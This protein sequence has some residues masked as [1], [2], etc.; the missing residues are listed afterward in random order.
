MSDTGTA[1]DPAGPA[2]R[3]VSADDQVTAP[4]PVVGPAPRPR[5]RLHRAGIH[6]VW[7]YDDQVFSFADGRLLL[8]G[9]N[10]AGKSKALEVLLP[11]LLDGDARRLDTTGTGRTSLR[12]LMQDGRSAAVLDDEDTEETSET[13]ESGGTAAAGS[14][15]GAGA[16]EG[17]GGPEG[18][19]GPEPA[20]DTGA[21]GTE[22]EGADTGADAAPDAAPVGDPAPP[23][24]AADTAP[25]GD[26]TEDTTS[27]EDTAPPA[28]R[29]GY[30]WIEFTREADTAAPGSRKAP[31][32]GADTRTPGRL[33]LGAAVTAVPGEE[34]RTLFFVTGRSVGDDLELVRGG[35]PVP[36]ERLRAEL[37][38]DSCYDSAPAYRGRVMRDLFGLDDPVRYRNLVHL[39]YRLRRPTIGERLEAGELVSVLAE[40]LP[41]MDEAVLDQVARNV[42]DLEEARSR[43]TALTAAAENVRAFLGDYRGYLHGVLG[44]RTSRVRG[45]LDGFGRRDAEAARLEEELDRLV[46]EEAAAQEERDRS[47]RTRDTAASDAA[48]LTAAGRAEP[49]PA[50]G[51]LQARDAAVAAYIRAAESA[52]TA[53]G[54]A[55]T[56]EER[57]IAA[58]GTGTAAVERTL[59][60]LEELHAEAADGARAAGMDPALLGRVPRPV[61]TV[62]TPRESTTHVDFEGLERAVERDPV[63]GIDL[64]ALR[65]GLADLHDRLSRAEAEAAERAA[66][67]ASLT[68]AA[69]RLDAAERRADALEG[70]AEAADAA[71]ERAR[72][73]EEAAVRALR[74]A[75]ADYA[76]RV[77]D[78]ARGVAEGFPEAAE[79]A[80]ALEELVHL[81]PG[82]GEAVDAGLC[83][84]VGQAAHALVDDLLKELRVRRD[85][86][87]G[88]ERELVT[89][90]DELSERKRGAAGDGPD[91]TPLYLLVDFAD[92]LSD[93]ERV[94]LEAALA[95]SGLLDARLA[96]DGTAQGSGDGALDGA[97]LAPGRP[98]DGASLLDVLRVADGAADEHGVPRDRVE[99]LLSSVAL[100][101]VEAG[102][103][104]DTAPRHRRRRDGE[105]PPSACAVAVDGRWRLGVASGAAGQIP[106]APERIGAGARA[107]ARDRR[108]ANVDRRIDIA[109]ALLAEAGERRAEAERAQERLVAAARALPG[110]EGP[111]R[112]RAALDEARAWL[113]TAVDEHDRAQEAADAAR[114]TALG[115]RTAVQEEAA[116]SGL[117]EG[118]EEAAATGTAVEGLR[119]RTGAA[120]R[121]LR[122]LAALLEEHRAAVED[123]R[124]ARADRVVAEDARTAAIGD[125]ITVRR[126]IELTDRARGADPG[127]LGSAVDEVRGR[128]DEAAARVPDL[129]RAAQR[130]RDERIAAETR[131]AAAV[132][133]RAEQADR[134]LSAGD[135]LRAALCGAD[136]EPDT[137]LLTAAGLEDVAPALAAAGAGAPTGEPDGGDADGGEA[138]DREADDGEPVGGAPTGEA[139]RLA[140]LEGLVGALEKGLEGGG[141]G[142]VDDSGLL[143]RREELHE[144]L[145][146]HAAARTEIAE[147]HGVKR[148]T[149]HDDSGARGVSGYAARLEELCAEAEEAALLREEE[150]YERHLLGELAEHLARRIDEAR[151]LVAA[152]NGVLEGVTTSQGIGVRI[153]WDMAPDADEDVRAVV[154][155]L[156]RPA[157]LRS[158]VETT[159]LRDALRRCIESIRRLD[160][161]AT[162]GA[163]LRQALDYRSWFSFE[164]RVTDAARPDTER[165]LS[166]RTGLSQGEQRVVAYL[167]LFAAA[168]AQFDS[169]AKSAPNAPRLILL[170]DA[171]AKVD[172]PTHGRLL[173]LLVELDLDFV[174]T[175][176]R[177]WGCF[178]S[179]P[180]LHIYE[181]LRD[182]AE[183][184][185][186]TLHFSWDGTRRRM[187]GV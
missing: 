139:E 170:D 6:N 72:A 184:G 29:V 127:Q 45:L 131:L 28:A 58:L 133:E 129:E 78:W 174:L 146:R 120:L 147:V 52:W 13:E 187:V 134:A 185:I 175:S 153:G 152:M 85:T 12:W 70:E 116:A 126:D 7:H 104:A 91:G 99:A 31:D 60:G 186:A 77:R 51:E 160:P 5:H 94:G 166:H 75:G 102:S 123:W 124:Q 73:R 68:A 65:T 34:P 86:S 112:A 62:L 54:Y 115:L 82:G 19:E 106:V 42:A 163:Q 121:V 18:P 61:R 8:R 14:S 176:E 2:G 151:E 27:S 88:E 69:G 165:R 47:R 144:A 55:L 172:E 117:P 143:R 83:D 9:R 40:A 105:R 24:A 140:A 89:E 56:R 157:H 21:D 33:T 39:L 110:G 53:A 63:P 169:L 178:E 96:P 108:L 20:A 32:G 10:G 177:V 164:V 84:R 113:D 149:V 22:D 57:A 137:D 15:A 23:A 182:P 132:A 156:A 93:A 90:L 64:E 154:P 71:L 11:F 135:R 76:G 92:G 80:T 38:A 95:A 161:T 1:P 180:S 67:V 136:G 30:L 66:A 118:A 167:V 145:G 98:A 114:G 59:D 181:C 141:S 159:R 179:V 183:P 16:G 46:T 36:V 49:A 162:G 150:A 168:A 155:L 128:M 44:R 3:E 79:A 43:R 111:A 37:G 35:R 50:E 142:E 26:T 87:L 130:A 101:P 122:D 100:L 125:M 173:G 74:A 81:P 171:F 119:V 109:E 17:A 138:V 107:A 41:P 97:V 103:A 4:L 48:T 25:S 158:R 148:V